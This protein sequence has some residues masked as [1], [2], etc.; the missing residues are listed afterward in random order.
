MR[1]AWGW[2][3]G[4]THDYPGQADS[5]PPAPISGSVAAGFCAVGI[6]NCLT[7]GPQTCGGRRRCARAE[8]GAQ[9]FASYRASTDPLDIEWTVA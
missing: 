5:T 7:R 6:G 8:H 9:S 4:R 1:V 2:S 3:S